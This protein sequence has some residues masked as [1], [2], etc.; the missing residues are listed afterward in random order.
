MLHLE[1]EESISLKIDT[2]KKA[3]L[4]TH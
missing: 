1:A 4:C 2:E 3:S